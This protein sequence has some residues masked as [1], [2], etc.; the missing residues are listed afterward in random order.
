MTAYNYRLRAEN[1][2]RKY[3]TADPAEIAASKGVTVL[4][5]SLPPHVCGL[6]KQVLRKKFI[7]YADRLTEWQIK[8]II[9]HELGHILLHPAY[10]H[11]AGPCS[12]Y[13][14]AK[15]EAEAD[16]FAVALCSLSSTDDELEAINSFLRTGWQQ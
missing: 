9:A 4:P 5:A 7:C 1:L 16:A 3:G 10:H 2:L 8:A 15:H 13:A 14:S 6:W 11:H 12:I